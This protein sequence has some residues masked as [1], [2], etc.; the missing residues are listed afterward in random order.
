MVNFEEKREMNIQ[1]QKLEIMQM[2]LE[3]NNPRILESI[4]SLFAKSKTSDFWKTLSQSQKEDIL[5]GIDEIES[6]EIVD[7]EDFIKKHR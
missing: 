1:A 3:T 5:Q 7:Y 4:K 2:I 6:G